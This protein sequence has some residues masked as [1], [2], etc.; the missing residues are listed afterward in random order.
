M[1]LNR[2]R[3]THGRKVP[4]L[5]DAIAQLKCIHLTLQSAAPKHHAAS[6]AHLLPVTNS[7][8]TAHQDLAQ[9]A[10]STDKTNAQRNSVCRLAHGDRPP[11]RPPI[12]RHKQNYHVKGPAD[13]HHQSDPCFPPH[14]AAC[15][16]HAGVRVSFGVETEKNAEC[17]PHGAF[18]PT[19][20]PSTSRALPDSSTASTKTGVSPSWLLRIEMTM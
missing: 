19:K 14:A 3:A 20:S 11:V 2:S 7:S 15:S 5:P 1:E 6:A 16:P 12:F 4:A 13:M 10:T 8:L 17:P 9:F 18:A